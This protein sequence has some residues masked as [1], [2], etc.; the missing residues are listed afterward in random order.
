MNVQELEARFREI[1]ERAGHESVE[2]K[3]AGD[4]KSTGNLS[5]RAS[6][7]GGR[8]SGR[9]AAPTGALESTSPQAETLLDVD[10]EDVHVPDEY[11]EAKIRAAFSK[12]SNLEAA[13]LL[14]GVKVMQ[15]AAGTDYEVVEDYTY[16]ADEYRI[17]APKGFV[18]DRASIPR[19]FWTIIDKDDLSNVPPLFHDLLYRNGGRLEQHLVS[20]FRTFER[21]EA[22]D[23]FLELMQKTGVRTWR[24]KAAYQA[25]RK[26]AGSHWRG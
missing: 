13:G 6:P 7:R 19:I 1:D 20:P 8:G 12:S 16:A 2:V 21:R 10:L 23:L 24:A 11:I 22:D 5:V 15:P 4:A 26:F 18:Y 17:T 9:K 3:V 14:P 25:V